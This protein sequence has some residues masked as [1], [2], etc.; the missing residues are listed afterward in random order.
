M[1][2]LPVSSIDSCLLFRSWHYSYIVICELFKVRIYTYKGPS[3]SFC[4]RLWQQRVWKLARHQCR[5]IS[6]EIKTLWHSFAFEVC[7]ENIETLAMAMWETCLSTVM[8][9][10]WK[11]KDD[12]DLTGVASRS[13]KNSHSIKTTINEQLMMRLGGESH[14]H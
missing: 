1:N 14:S 2:G 8:E 4:L 10:C 12:R 5:Y 3:K 6:T 11:F 13:G 9:W 7:V